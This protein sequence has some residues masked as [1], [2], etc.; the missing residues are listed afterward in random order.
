M[1]FEKSELTLIRD[2]IPG[3]H[4]SS[5]FHLFELS[6]G[7]HYPNIRG[8]LHIKFICVV[9]TITKATSGCDVMAGVNVAA[10]TL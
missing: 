2:K 1:S 6:G 7:L 5:P 9:Q 10:V 8:L 4:Q 3:E